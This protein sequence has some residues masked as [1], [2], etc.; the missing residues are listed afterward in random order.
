MPGPKTRV[1]DQI[2]K[3]M[4]N[5]T[6]FRPLTRE[7]T[8]RRRE[9]RTGR[10]AP[11]GV[12]HAS[13]P[14]K[15]GRAQNDDPQLQTARHHRPVRRPR[16]RHRRGASPDPPPPHRPRRFGL[17]QM[18]RPAHPPRPRRPHRARQPLRPQIRTGAHLA[19]APQAQTLAPTLHHHLGVVGDGAVAGGASRHGAQLAQPVRADRGGRCGRGGARPG[20]QAPD[21]RRAGGGDRVRHAAHRARR[22]LRGVV[23]PDDGR[24]PRREQ[25]HRVAH[26]ERE[27]PAPVAHRHVQALDRPRLRGQTG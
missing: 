14:I 24:P 13:D 11:A 18:D 7:D 2:L 1:W 16:R 17:L 10:P 22:R 27:G 8:R 5:D 21:H 25:E 12:L 6:G 20:P 26:L 23:H 15:P 3:T 19:R 9:A 4:K